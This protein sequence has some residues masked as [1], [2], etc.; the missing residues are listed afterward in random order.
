[1]IASARWPGK[2]ASRIERWR[3]PFSSRDHA[4]EDAVPAHEMMIEGAP[5]MHGDKPLPQRVVRAR[6]IAAELV[7]CG[8]QRCAGKPDETAVWLIQIHHEIDCSG[9]R[10]GG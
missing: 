3:S 1:M 6:S 8:L 4:H 2:D 5:H 7:E 9:N 10:Q